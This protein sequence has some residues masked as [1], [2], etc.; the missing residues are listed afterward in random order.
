MTQINLNYVLL[1]A[2]KEFAG[3]EVFSFTPNDTGLIP[4]VGDHVSFG[5]DGEAKVF[6][7]KNR[8]FTLVSKDS[9]DI[10]LT[11]DKGSMN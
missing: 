11:L 3:K 8:C 4:Q 9:T 2:A 1:G 7:V 5:V 10:I 6:V